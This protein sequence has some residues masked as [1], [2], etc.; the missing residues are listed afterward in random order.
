MKII[1]VLKLGREMLKLL[2]KKGSKVT[3]WQYVELYE[4]FTSMREQGMKVRG[5]AMELSER[6]GIAVST[7]FKIVNRL[8]KDC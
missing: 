6:Y 2:S 4:E 5:I 1:D 8:S 7:L 3:D